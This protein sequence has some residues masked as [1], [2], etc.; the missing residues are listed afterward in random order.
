MGKLG[1][2][3]QPSTLAHHAFVAAGSALA[4]SVCV[5]QPSRPFVGWWVSDDEG[6]DL[7]ADFRLEARF[8]DGRARFFI[9]IDRVVG[10]DAKFVSCW[11]AGKSS[12]EPRVPAHIDSR[13][14]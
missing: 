6:F 4:S 3:F 7:D 2:N 11:H 9:A 12:T 14:R 13:A 5:I 10:C 8:D 1:M